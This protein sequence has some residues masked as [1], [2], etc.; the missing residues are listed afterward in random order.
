[1]HRLVRGAGVSLSEGS[2]RVGSC[3]AGTILVRVASPSRQPSRSCFRGPG[4]CACPHLAV[5]SRVG[6]SE[7]GATQ[8]VNPTCKE[9]ELCLAA[10]GVHSDLPHPGLAQTAGLTATVAGVRVILWVSFA[11]PWGQTVV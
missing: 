5:G 6:A 1:M 8:A 4:T 2:S 10:A 7:D 11:R 3:W 9:S